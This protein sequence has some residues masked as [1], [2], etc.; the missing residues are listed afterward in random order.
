MTDR[1]RL[2][3]RLVLACMVSCLCLRAAVADEP[4]AEEKP[5]PEKMT[6]HREVAPPV[7]TVQLKPGEVPAIAFETPV[8]D[9]G[10]AQAGT[11]VKH[12]YKF[13]N[14]GNGPLEILRVKPGCGCTTAG[15]H[16]K[17][18]QP[19]ESGVIPIKLKPGDHAGPVSKRITVST[20]IPGNDATIVLE[21][22]GVV[23]SPVQ[24]TPRSA[25]FGRLTQDQ[26]EQGLSRKLVVVNNME[27]PMKPGALTSTND[28]FVAE[29]K[30]VEEG[31]KYELIVT[32]TNKIAGGNNSTRLTFDTGLADP[33]TI[34]VQAYAF[35]SPPVDVTPSK[36]TLPKPRNAELVRSFYIRSNTANP[37]DVTDLACSAPAL[38]L[39][40]VDLRGD[41]RTYRLSVTIP[42]DYNPPAQGDEITFKT[43]EPSMEK[44]SIPITA[45]MTGETPSTMTER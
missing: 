45:A 22:K 1:T 11:E 16:T 40:L 30:T 23:W 6:P 41:K 36:L 38:K 2:A 39:E 7:P 4:K 42:A 5:T 37:L 12:D 32:L 21:I 29:M 28:A 44:G 14:M 27:A 34:D 3:R 10:K 18:V 26:I 19:G 17:I 24:V 25:A 31:K 13:R 33:K 43:S 9:F 35:L 15:E 20:N 8:Y